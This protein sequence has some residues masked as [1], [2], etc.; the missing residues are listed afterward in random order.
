MLGELYIFHI[1]VCWLKHNTEIICIEDIPL[2]FNTKSKIKCLKLP[3][4]HNSLY[5]YTVVVLWQ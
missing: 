4:K 1:N 2:S 3:S 5:L